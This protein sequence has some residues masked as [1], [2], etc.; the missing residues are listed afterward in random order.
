MKKRNKGELPSQA[1]LIA[2]C[3][4]VAVILVVLILYIVK[5]SKG[6]I[7]SGVE[8]YENAVSQYSEI[9]KTQYD[10][11]DVPGSEVV[12]IIKK[13]CEEGNVSVTVKTLANTSGKTYSGT[14]VYSLQD[15]PTNNDYIKETGVFRGEVVTNANG[16]V[17]Q[18]IFTQH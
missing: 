10:G 5:T 3:I 14:T 4:L 17:T 18:I 8:Q 16:V 1:L 9:E 6:T 12:T 13:M 15:S 2:G 7:N 11:L